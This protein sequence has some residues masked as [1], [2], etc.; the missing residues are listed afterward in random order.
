MRG[1]D[2][3]DKE[4]ISSI[5]FLLM[6]SQKYSTSAVFQEMIDFTGQFRD[7]APYNNM[8]SA[9]PTAGRTLGPPRPRV[10]H[11][12]RIQYRIG[13]KRS[14]NAHNR[15]K[16]AGSDWLRVSAEFTG[17]SG[18]FRS[19][20][21]ADGCWA[22][23]LRNRGLGFRIPLGVLASCRTAVNSPDSLG[24]TPL[25]CWLAGCSRSPKDSR[26]RTSRAEF[27][28]WPFHGSH[29]RIRRAD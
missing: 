1:K 14:E 8:L 7:Y 24:L 25:E 20:G 10:A 28:R 3:L 21:D 17:I 13:C 18:T 16:F 11:R 5:D 22:I 27:A 19:R 26:S 15:A 2:A 6:K 23:C 4:V 9:H 29:S 12:Y